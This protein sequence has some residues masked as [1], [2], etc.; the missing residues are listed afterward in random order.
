MKPYFGQARALVPGDNADTWIGPG[1]VR[2]PDSSAPQPPGAWIDRA[3]VPR[4]VQSPNALGLAHAGPVFLP[5]NARDCKTEPAGRLPL[6]DGRERPDE[7][8]EGG[9]ERA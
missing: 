8:V 4:T 6:E 7:P 3:L 2:A 5:A 1:H 9:R